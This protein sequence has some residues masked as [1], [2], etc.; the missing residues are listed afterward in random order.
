M[1]KIVCVF[2]L[3]I[4]GLFIF[5]LQGCDWI[6]ANCPTPPIQPQD[7][8]GYFFTDFKEKNRKNHDNFAKNISKTGK[9]LETGK[10]T[11]EMYISEIQK[12]NNN[13]AA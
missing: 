13:L 4:G 12:H 8:S 2:A 9:K 1:K 5:G 11:A 7:P 3:F 6:C 10:I